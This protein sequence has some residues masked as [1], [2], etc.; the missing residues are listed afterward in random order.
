MSGEAGP[1]A[2]KILR[3]LGMPTDVPVAALAKHGRQA[4]LR[5]APDRS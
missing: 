5:D 3:R 4:E 1:V 2:E